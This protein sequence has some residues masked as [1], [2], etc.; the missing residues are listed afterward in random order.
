MKRALVFQHMDHDHPGR[1]LDF[2]AEDD[3][4]IEPVRL[5]ENQA[6]PAL[7]PYD[8]LFVLGGK[9]DCWEEDIYPWLKEEKQA[10]REWVLERAKPYFGVC[11]GHQLLAAATGGDVALADSKE[12]GVCEIELTEAGIEHPF[13]KGVPRRNPVL[14][15]HMAEVKKVGPDT[16]ILATSDRA[17]VQSIAVG[18][19]AMATQFHC[20][21]TLQTIAGWA[22]LPKYIEGLEGHLGSGYYPHFMAKAA[23]LMPEIDRS[24][25]QMYENLA[26][27]SGLRK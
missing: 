15:W 26:R 12:I 20:E 16:K 10:I 25:R 19:H 4:V 14:Q 3:L 24:T 6:I 22:S 23:R 7:A 11:L 13:M 5:F 9:Q 21:F 27:A 1:F 18:E 17:N 2:L 8:F